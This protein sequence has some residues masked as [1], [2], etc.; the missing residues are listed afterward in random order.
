MVLHCI[1][2]HL[3][4]DSTHHQFLPPPP[5]ADLIDSNSRAVKVK[6]ELYIGSYTV[7]VAVAAAADDNQ[8]LNYGSTGT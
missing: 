5:A 6:L 4:L 2:A 8:A 3:D 7:A 1:H